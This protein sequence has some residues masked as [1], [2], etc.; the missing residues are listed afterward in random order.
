MS[1]KVITGSEQDLIRLLADIRV[2]VVNALKDAGR[3]V[4][5][6]GNL[7]CCNE[8]NKNA[9]VKITKY[10]SIEHDETQEIYYVRHFDKLRGKGWDDHLDA[11]EELLTDEF[12]VADDFEPTSEAIT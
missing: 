4:D 5:A 6:D 11:I 1:I 9:S 7:N 3:D 12:E 10:G 8:A 2:I